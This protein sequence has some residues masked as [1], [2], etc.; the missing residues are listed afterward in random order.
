MRLLEDIIKLLRYYKIALSIVLII[1]NSLLVSCQVMD[2]VYSSPESPS[3]KAQVTILICKLIFQTF[4]I[5]LL[6][7][8]L[9]NIKYRKTCFV[10]TIV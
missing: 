3:Y 10:L 2:V 8:L 6:I 1:S 4:L 7:F 5:I 9:I